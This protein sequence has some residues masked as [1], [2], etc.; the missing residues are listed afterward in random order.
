MLQK[1]AAIEYVE[2]STPPFLMTIENV[3]PLETF[4]SPKSTQRCVLAS[5]TDAPATGVFAPNSNG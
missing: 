4:R 1:F 3:E 2:E 5:N